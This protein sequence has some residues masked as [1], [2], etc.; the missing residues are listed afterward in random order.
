MSIPAFPAV[1][2]A[3]TVGGYSY[4]PQENVIR[5]DMEAG[6]ARQRRRFTREATTVSLQFIF[7]Q[8]EM[9][10]FEYWFRN[11]AKHG[12]SW[13]DMNLASGAGIQQVQARFVAPYK[14]KALP[15]LNYEVTGDVEV[16]LMPVISQ[17]EY[18]NLTGTV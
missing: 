5:T 11:E 10:V 7:T 15:G 6:P 18:D 16:D 9:G 13:F 1:L 14:A 8:T 12:A 2:P 4:K 3:P 17:A